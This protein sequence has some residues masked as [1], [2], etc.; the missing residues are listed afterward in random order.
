MG[1]G[2]GVVTDVDRIYVMRQGLGVFKGSG[3]VSTIRGIEFA[4]DHKLALA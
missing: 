2:Q 3:G 4:G 1:L